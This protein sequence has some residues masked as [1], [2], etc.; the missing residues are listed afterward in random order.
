MDDILRPDRTDGSGSIMRVLWLTR[1]FPD[2]A[3][4]GDLLYTKGMVGALALA[5]VQVTVLC[6]KTDQ[7]DPAESITARAV[8]T[9]SLRKA[10]K[11][12]A[13]SLASSLPSDAYTLSSRHFERELIKQLDGTCWDAVI[14]DY[15]AMGW[16][17]PCLRRWNKARSRRPC[18]VYVAHNHETSLRPQVAK[19]YSLTGSKIVN[20]VARAA[21]AYDA[22]KY[23]ALE[24]DLLKEA[25]L[26]TAITESDRTLLGRAAL[27]KPI[28]CLLPG[29]S[30]KP[31]ADW[32]LD[33]ATPRRVVIVG[34]F[35]W[36]AKQQNLLEF[37]KIADPKFSAKRIELLV[38]GRAGSTFREA[39]KRRSETCNFTGPVADV[40][41][42]LEHARMGVMAEQ[43]GGGFKLKLLDYVFA[44]LPIAAIDHQLAGLPLTPDK[45]VLAASSVEQL[46]DLLVRAIDDL[47][48]LNRLRSAALAKCADQFN[49]LSRGR[50]LADAIRD[51]SALIASSGGPVLDTHQAG[52]SATRQ[53]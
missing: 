2:R 6:F 15:V 18:L 33:E 9:V 38:V 52:S 29:Y 22:R 4:R 28:I 12:R 41:P 43:V 46:C 21:L 42:Y 19:A 5:N 53:A 23:A 7:A 35:D 8:R 16:V 39:V 34:S 40:S 51:V 36:V 32:V 50:Q 3:D 27:D 49:W 14:I 24:A 31:H 17:L 37:V 30:G 48:L 11:R 25:D 20:R 47:P 10:K 44:G 13:I 26:V 45:E 1:E